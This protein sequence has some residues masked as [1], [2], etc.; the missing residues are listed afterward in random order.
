[1]N[2][3]IIIK[4]AK[5]HN[6]KN[7]DLTLPKNKL[8]VFTG[9]SGSGKS[10]LA[11]D[12]IFAEGQRRY[13]ESLSP[14]ARQFLGQM[15]AP[16][17]EEITGLSPAI[18][19]DQKG[20][21]HNPRSTVATLTE[22]Y[23]YMRVL[24]ARLGKPFCPLC[25]G[26][27][28]K[29][30]PQEMIDVVVEG[31]KGKPIVVL[32]PVVRGRKGE[33]YQL[34]YDLLS[35]GFSQIR[36]DGKFY[37]L[38]DRINLSRYKAHNIDLVVD[39]LLPSDASRLSEAV[40]SALQYGKGLIKVLIENKEII[41]SSK[42]SCPRDDFAFAE[43]EPRLFSFNSPYG[44]CENCHGLGKEFIYSDEPCHKCEGNR[45][46]NAALSVK[47]SAKGGPA[48]GGKNIAEV[49]ALTIDKAY[50]FFINMEDKLKASEKEIAKTVLKEII[51]RLSFLL[52]V[53]LD[54]IALNREAGSLSGGESQR[55]R[56]AS[57]IGS[58]LSGT[59]YVLDEPTIGLH[60]RDNERL[61]KTLK[62]LRDLGNTVIVVEHD[63]RTIND[64]DYL[65]DLGPGPGRHGGEV[66][67]AQETKE[68][69]K[70]NYKHNSLTVKYIKG[71]E[72][73]E[74]PQLRRTGSQ[75]KIKIVG[76]TANNLK[77]IN[78]DIPLRRFVCI[79]GVS[80]SG[81]STLVFDILSKGARR[82]ID[83]INK[84]THGVAK[85]LG[86]EYL[87]SVI[88]VDQSPIGRT[89]RSNPA[90]YTGVFT[91]IRDL[92]AFLP[93]AKE[94]SFGVS[95]FS[96]NRSG[97][98]C[99]A[100][101]GAGS[102]LIEMHF[103]PP[104]L[105]TCDV[106]RG[107]RFNNETLEVRYKGKNIA[108]VLN[109]TVEEACDIFKDIYTI[110]DKLKVLNQ[111]G[112]GYIRL[113]QSATTLSGGEAQRIKLAKYLARPM[114]RKSLF[115]LDEPTTGLHFEDI[116]MLLRVL[117]ELVKR[118]NTVVVIEHNLHVIKCADYVIDLGPE[119]GDKGGKVVACGT[120]EEVSKNKNSYTGQYLK[121]V[122]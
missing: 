55:I 66:V 103:L 59:L 51:S 113:G 39:N 96:F 28:R 118:G 20:H 78:T 1:M 99:E 43:I 26:E 120:P 24:F 60:E 31:A 48:S 119:G 74:I 64:S 76:A 93:E 65:V 37:S 89:P 94:R 49:S 104:V 95:R 68:I 34:L 35:D 110:A 47:I 101:E 106:C 84:E 58:K 117:D 14:Y 22:I 86:F 98:R 92:F 72:E 50:E 5:V 109:L 62:E 19:I 107:K 83:H 10:S 25:G 53:G 70:K 32:A 114:H 9:V 33:Y 85:V 38:H 97:G 57:Q 7:I 71:E 69:L 73:I 44:A 67:L 17:V 105:V 111:V 82:G 8:I 41:L 6:L 52:E 18:A 112:L 61:L 12:T 81:K 108:D 16:D 100:C 21:S 15:D 88:E 90:T 40:D 13:V 56:L 121:K 23:D 91:P 45:L 75:E 80:G 115:L 116:K 122:L 30:S 36:V 42:W 102:K 87:D 77:N 79:T 11:F 46:N 3:K 2:D 4:G 54:Y 27:I 63:E 29:L